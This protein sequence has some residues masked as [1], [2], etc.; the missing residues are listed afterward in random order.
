MY[1]VQI[2]DLDLTDDIRQF[3]LDGAPGTNATGPAQR[4]GARWL[5]AQSL[6]LRS[7]QTLRRQLQSLGLPAEVTHDA[8]APTGAHAAPDASEAD[9]WQAVLGISD[10]AS[11][12]TS[13]PSQGWEQV[14]A[15]PPRF[16]LTSAP[17]ATSSP[18]GATSS[19][20]GADLAALHDFDDFAALTD[21]AAVSPLSD[22][23][24][25]DAAS[26]PSRAPSPSPPSPPRLQPPKAASLKD[27]PAPPPRPAPSRAREAAPAPMAREPLI[28]GDHLPSRRRALALLGSLG[29]AVL[30][31]MLILSNR[32]AV[33]PVIVGADSLYE[34]YEDP[35]DPTPAQ[36]PEEDAPV[37]APP[38]TFTRPPPP[39]NPPPD[40]D[41][42]AARR[43]Q[44]QRANV[45]FLE[46]EPLCEAGVTARC[47]ALL[48]QVILLDPTR[49]RAYELLARAR[50]HPPTP[51][52]APTP[53]LDD[54]LPS[55]DIPPPLLDLSLEPPNGNP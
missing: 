39:V 22:E 6:P 37:S 36:D 1:A 35:L 33:E 49:R 25:Q 32:P 43:A 53:D 15:S 26:T 17:S 14:G 24:R 28:G 21:L 38:Q 20:A 10:D 52:E 23:A 12:A 44:M 46:A 34:S 51:D 40:S 3:L 18:A 47:V 54:A 19:P 50:M 9:P 30:W 42:Q 48:E 4:V 27:L 41:T 13:P 5:I 45:L 2:P 55:P 29:I 8:G 16:A 31:L 7:A 11:P